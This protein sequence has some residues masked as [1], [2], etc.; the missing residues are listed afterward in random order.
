MPFLSVSGTKFFFTEEGNGELVVLVHGSL[1]DYRDWERQIEPLSR[2]GFKAVAYSRRNHHPNPWQ[3]YPPNYSL[4]TERDDL[5][6]IL[7][8]LGE[9]AHLIGHSYGGYVAALVARDYPDLVKKLVIAEPPIFTL[10]RE[11]KDKLLAERFLGEV[12]E[13]AKKSLKEITWN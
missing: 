13:P 1:G 2:S 3:D 11:D 8:E 9:R 7:K 5:A 10:P 4:K 6:W 12:I